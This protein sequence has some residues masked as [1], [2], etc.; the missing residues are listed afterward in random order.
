MRNEEESAGFSASSSA[1]D[2]AARML[3]VAGVDA[4]QYAFGKTRIFIKN[5]RTV[6]E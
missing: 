2:M 3:R 1:A 4:S 5:R 6:S